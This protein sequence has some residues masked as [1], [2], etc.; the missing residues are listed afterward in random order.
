[1]SVKEP[2]PKPGGATASIRFG[3]EAGHAANAGLQAAMDLIEP[4]K[5]K[6]PLVGGFGGGAPQSRIPGARPARAEGPPFPSQQQTP[7]N[8]TPRFPT[9]TSIRWR[10][11]WRLSW[12]AG[13]TS[14]CATAAWTRSPPRTAPPTVRAARA[15]LGAASSLRPV[16]PCSPAF[17]SPAWADASPRCSHAACRRPQAAS[18]LRGTPSGTAA[19]RLRSTCARSFTAWWGPLGGGLELLDARAWSYL[20]VKRVPPNPG[21]CV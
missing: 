18:R 11:R 1:M 10:A 14:R 15:L 5:Q 9:P 6:F 12:R 16:P 2:W 21:L 4:I 7:S 19:S 8:P 17:I 3:P 13:P 20:G